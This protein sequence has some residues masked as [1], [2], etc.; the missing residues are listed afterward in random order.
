MTQYIKDFFGRVNDRGNVD[1]LDLDGC[2]TILNSDP[3]IDPISRGRG[4]GT[5]ISLDDAKRINLWIEDVSPT[6]WPHGS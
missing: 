5:E 3:A 4:D 6:D 1:V 2:P